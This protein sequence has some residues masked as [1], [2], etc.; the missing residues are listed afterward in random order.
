MIHI[1]KKPL[2]LLPLEDFMEGGYA[3]FYSKLKR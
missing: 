2:V 1:K 3:P